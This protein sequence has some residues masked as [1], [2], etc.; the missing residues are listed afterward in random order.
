MDR[1]SKLSNIYRAMLRRCYNPNDN[2]YLVYG[3]R[4]IAVC[5][6]WLNKERVY[7]ITGHPSKGWITFKEWALSHGYKDG[8]SIDRIDNDKGY[9]P[10]NCRWVTLKEQSLN[11]RDTF[12]VTYKGKTKTLK[13]LSEELGFDYIKA[14]KRI[15]Y[16]K[17]SIERSIET[18]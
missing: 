7:F 9:S 14:W 2:H 11:K 10:E 12:Y 17:W 4:G 8:L 6:E 3:G 16:Y 1:H 5:K 18:K 15:K 13:T